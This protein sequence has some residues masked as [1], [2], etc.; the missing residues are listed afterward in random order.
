MALLASVSDVADR[1]G[2]ELVQGRDTEVLALIEEASAL[3]EGYVG[4]EL[5]PV[6]RPVTI[7]VS[8]MVARVLQAPAASFSVDTISQNA[9]PFS[10]SQTFTTGSS[11]GAPWLTNQDKVVLNRFRK[12]RGFYSISMI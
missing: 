9:G 11:G 1:V 8:R 12:R 5:A 6:P 2:A 3:V 4:R 7:V 10:Q